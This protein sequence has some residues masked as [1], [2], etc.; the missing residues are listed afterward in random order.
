MKLMHLFHEETLDIHERMSSSSVPFSKHRSA[1][2]ALRGGNERE[3]QEKKGGRKEKADD[4]QYEKT[5]HCQR[6]G[7][8]QD[9]HADRSAGPLLTDA[10]CSIHGEPPI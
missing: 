2:I 3:R 5:Q 7:E 8:G 6:Y 9:N 1:D 10:L 4:G